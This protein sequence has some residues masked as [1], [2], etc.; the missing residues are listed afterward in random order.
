MP[1]RLKPTHVATIERW[2]RDDEDDNGDSPFP[3][4]SSTSDEGGD[5]KEIATDVPCALDD[6]STAYIRRD[7]GSRVE[8]PLTATFLGRPGLEEDDRVTL[9]PIADDVEIERA[10]RAAGVE[11]T[12]DNRR[13]GRTVSVS[14][15]L[16]DRA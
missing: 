6:E 13:R 2:E 11:S 16:E 8:D 1:R 15:E 7:D 5:W 10:F 4:S 9:E 3:E 12:Y 14:V